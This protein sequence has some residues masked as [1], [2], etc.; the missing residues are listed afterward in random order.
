[1]KR[2]VAIAAGMGLAAATMMAQAGEGLPKFEQLDAD[3]DGQITAAEAK[4]DEQ[5]SELFESIDVDQNGALS[6][7]E[8]QQAA[9]PKK[10]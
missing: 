7:D 1:M 8:Y 9:E 10:M 6:A 2:F 4:V 3:Q 5:L